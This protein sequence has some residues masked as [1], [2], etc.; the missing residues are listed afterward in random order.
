VETPTDPNTAT[1]RVTCIGEDSEIDPGAV[2]MIRMIDAPADQVGFGYDGTA[3]SFT[4]D[5][6]GIAERLVIRGATYEIRREGTY[7]QWQTYV[8]PTDEDLIEIDSFVQP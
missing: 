3:A 8:M 4:A 2:V 6:N 5:S 7:K 1:L